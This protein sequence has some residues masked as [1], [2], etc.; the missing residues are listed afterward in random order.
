SYLEKELKSA[1]P[2][3]RK[4]F[5]SKI[6]IINQILSSGNNDLREQSRA[7]WQEIVDHIIL[8]SDFKTLFYKVSKGRDITHQNTTYAK[9][10]LF[11]QFA[12]RIPRERSMENLG[13][14]N[15]VYPS[16]ENIELP[17]E[18]AALGISKAEWRNILK[19]AA[20]Y[21]IRYG[22]HFAI[23]DSIRIFSTKQQRSYS[24]FPP[25]SKIGDRWPLY[26]RRSKTQSRFILLLC[27]GLGWH[28]Q[29]D[30]T[31]ERKDQLEALSRKIW[32]T[33]R[34]RLLHRD[35][36]RYKLNLTEKSQFQLA[37]KVFLCPS[38][39]RL[40]DTHFRGY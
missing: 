30:F 22:Y 8:S 7:T 36:N 24:I 27:A 18:A 16:L 32:E 13:L 23:D 10:L 39:Q 33:L 3:L 6:E 28:H 26:N 38:S 4:E 31:E 12:R 14:V 34:A 2:F 1:P 29:D 15:L 40:I 9:A 25:E 20:D 37:E 5:E 21:V 17:D 35:S 19:I 11:D